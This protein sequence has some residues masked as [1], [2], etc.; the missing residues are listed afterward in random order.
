MRWR[1]MVELSGV[2]GRAQTHELHVGSCTLTACSAE[3]LGLT[4]AQAKLL[5]AELQRH[6]VQVQTEEYWTPLPAM[7]RATAAEGPAPSAAALAVRRR[8][9]SCTP[10]RPLPMQW[11]PSPNPVAGRGGHAPSPHAGI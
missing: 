11:G 8:G 4:L 9:G 1:V 3:T 7:R 5:L 2:D 6:L 10:L